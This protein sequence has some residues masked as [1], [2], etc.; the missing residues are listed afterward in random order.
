MAETKNKFQQK[1]RVIT[2]LRDSGCRSEKALHDLPMETVL[3]IP[4][5]NLQDI[6]IILEVKK[7]VKSNHLFSYLT[8]AERLSKEDAASDTADTE[9]TQSDEWE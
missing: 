4:G 9:D 2:K 1:M 5:I 3:T 7:Q 8:E 6:G